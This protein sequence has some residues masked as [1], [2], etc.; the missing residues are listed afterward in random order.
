[1]DNNGNATFYGNVTVKGSMT[2]TSSTS[3][4]SG[5]YLTVTA[6]ELGIGIIIVDQQSG[7][8]DFCAD[9]ISGAPVGKCGKI[10]AVKPSTTLPAIPP[11]VTVVAPSSGNVATNGT[12]GASVYLVNNQT[13]DVSQCSYINENGTPTGTCVD[14]GVAPQ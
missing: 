10:G 12:D 9:D 4:T 6:A 5:R 2:T 14:L 8:V 13:G 11:G 7:A 1:M 3:S